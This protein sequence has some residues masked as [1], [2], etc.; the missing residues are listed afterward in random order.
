M[1]SGTVQIFVF[2]RAMSRPITRTL[3]SP[4]PSRSDAASRSNS[5]FVSALCWKPQSE[6]KILVAANSQGAIKVL[7]LQCS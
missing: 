7:Q 5:Q 2:Y 4:G 1:K 6:Q 3:F